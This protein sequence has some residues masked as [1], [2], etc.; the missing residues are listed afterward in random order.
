MTLDEALNDLGQ[1]ITGASSG[2]VL[3]T[4]RL[5]SEEATIRVYAPAS[6]EAAIKAAL[7][8]TTISLLTEH[9]LDVQVLVYDIATDLPPDA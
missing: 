8:D 9:G 7:R 4:Q 5:G 6:D 3:R 1:K 2:A